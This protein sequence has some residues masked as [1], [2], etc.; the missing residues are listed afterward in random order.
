MTD[1][2]QTFEEATTACDTISRFLA[3]KAAE[4]AAEKK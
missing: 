1:P 3:R 4:K 2:Y